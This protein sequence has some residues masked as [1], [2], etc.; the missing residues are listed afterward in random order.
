MFFWKN[1]GAKKVSSARNSRRSLN[2]TGVREGCGGLYQSLSKPIL[3][4]VVR[5]RMKLSFY[6]YL[7]MIG[8]FSWAASTKKCFRAPKK[9]MFL[10]E[11]HRNTAKLWSFIAV[12]NIFDTILERSY[13]NITFLVVETSV[14]LIMPKFWWNLS[15][16]N[17]KI[18]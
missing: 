18:V 12:K 16:D 10:C 11:K 8:R 7:G 2:T 17:R 4:P 14:R 15:L 3:F 5:V 13:T 6:Q 1:W 9:M